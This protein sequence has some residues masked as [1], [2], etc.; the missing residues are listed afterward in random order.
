MYINKFNR[1]NYSQEFIRIMILEMSL[2]LSIPL[3]DK[4]EICLLKEMMNTN[5]RYRLNHY[6]L[7][8]KILNISIDELLSDYDI[9][10]LIKNF[11]SFYDEQQNSVASIISFF[12]EIN[13]LKELIINHEKINE[14]TE[15]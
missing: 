14:L 2:D 10:A 15:S 1:L 5:V 9:R 8:S 4:D 3:L 12:S 7:A 11:D 13:G 6:K